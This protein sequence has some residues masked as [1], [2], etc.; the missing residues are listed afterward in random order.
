MY[1]DIQTLTYNDAV[2]Y[3]LYGIYSGQQYSRGS[4]VPVLGYAVMDE[5]HIHR[6]RKD[7]WLGGTV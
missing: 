2:H 3:V 4:C 6:R 1:S 5:C 7:F